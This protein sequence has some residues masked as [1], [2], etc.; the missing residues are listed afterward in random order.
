[1]RA[2]LEPDS[3]RLLCVLPV[4]LEVCCPN[5][6]NEAIE[7]LVRVFARGVLLRRPVVRIGAS[8][9]YRDDQLHIAAPGDD[10]GRSRNAIMTYSSAVL[11][12]PLAP[13]STRCAAFTRRFL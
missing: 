3:S 10:G 4:R 12:G 6:Q 13:V 11:F 2:G 1:M 7:V 9:T 5:G 8:F